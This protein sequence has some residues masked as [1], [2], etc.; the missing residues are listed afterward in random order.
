MKFEHIKKAILINQEL[1]LEKDE[2]TPSFKVIPRNVEK[3]FSKYIN[4]MIE[5]RLEDLPE[6]AQIVDVCDC[7]EVV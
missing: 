1:S 5:D 4:C 6:D 3:N 7:R 2:L